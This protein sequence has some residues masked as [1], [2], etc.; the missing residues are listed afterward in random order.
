MKSF[1]LMQVSALPWCHGEQEAAA[2]VWEGGKLF[3]SFLKRNFYT[4][5]IAVCKTVL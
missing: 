2:D 4:F 5:A 3:M 1:I